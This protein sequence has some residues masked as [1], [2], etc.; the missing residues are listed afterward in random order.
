MITVKDCS[1]LPSQFIAYTKTVI[2]TREGVYYCL[3]I[4]LKG[5]DL[6]G[7]RIIKKEEE[8]NDDAQYIHNYYEPCKT[9][10]CE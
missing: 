8:R 3:C 2:D 6:G 4:Y 7:R 9:N 5:V 1:F 10:C